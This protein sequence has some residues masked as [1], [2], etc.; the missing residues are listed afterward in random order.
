MLKLE[1]SKKFKELYNQVPDDK[2]IIE[3]SDAIGI[4]IVRNY[5]EN[6]EYFKDG[7]QMFINLY[8]ND[9]FL[10]GGIQMVKKEK[11]GEYISINNTNKNYKKRFTNF[12]FGSEEKIRLTLENNKISVKVQNKELF[13]NSFVDKLV[14]NHLSDKLFWIRKKNFFKQIFL[15]IL[16]F[17]SDDKYD[18]VEYYHKIHEWR[19]DKINFQTEE[20]KELNVKVEPFFHY[21]KIFKNTLFIFCIISLFILITINNQTI[22]PTDEISFSNPIF[23]L[24]FII[25]LFLLHFFSVFLHK[26]KQ[27]KNGF[28][29]KLHNSLLNRNLK[30][31]F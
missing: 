13:L 31:N 11:N 27:D 16:F 5:N 19:E 17:L 7:N 30:L 9:N 26:K 22:P 3:L 20:E 23:L 15:K 2:K 1:T 29:H 21:L 8:L 14:Q 24:L 18:F 12:S 10:C 4:N 28:I 6:N 25:A